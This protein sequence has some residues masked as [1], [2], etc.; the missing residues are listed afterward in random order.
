M[1]SPLIVPSRLRYPTASDPRVIEAFGAIELDDFRRLLDPEGDVLALVIRGYYPVELCERF[2]ARLDAGDEVKF[3]PYVF[4]PKLSVTK[5][6]TTFGEACV[7]PQMMD[8][9]FDQ[10][11]ATEAL[12]RSF[13]APYLSPLDK[14]RLDLDAL[15]PMGAEVGRMYG[16]R[17]LS[18]FLR[19]TPVNGEIPPHQDDLLE[20]A[21]RP[22]DFR[23]AVELVQNLYLSMP[24]E[25]FGGELQIFDY[26]PGYAEDLAEAYDAGKSDEQALLPA[27]AAADLESHPSVTIRP[28]VGDL[29][30]FKGNFVHRVQ[31]VQ[32]GGRVTACCHVAHVNDAEPLRCWI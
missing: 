19:N 32:L 3:G 12:L 27:S 21:P 23:P 13:F 7:L 9:Y 18:G 30:F 25:G 5:L 2:T 10:V 16:R 17:M 1:N 11:S 6:G 14:V 24:P 31:K 8:D 20:E 29:V 15:W 4:A 22:P 28:E 26:A